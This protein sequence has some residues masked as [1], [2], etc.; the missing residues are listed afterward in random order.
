MTMD[1]HP[2]VLLTALQGLAVEVPFVGGAMFTVV[3]IA[4]G[5]HPVLVLADFLLSHSHFKFLHSFAFV[6]L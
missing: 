3:S 2:T 4:L 5:V 6:L 1:F